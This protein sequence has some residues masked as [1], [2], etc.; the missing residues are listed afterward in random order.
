MDPEL[1]RIRACARHSIGRGF[2]FALLAIVTT[3]AGMIG[4]PV[5]AMRMGALLCML[6]VVVFVLR[7]RRAPLH[8]YR[9]TETWILL[10]RRHA[11]PE[12]RAQ[13]A[14]SGILAETYWRFADTSAALALAL[15]IATF[16]F[17]LLGLQRG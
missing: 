8:P 13:A 6:M 7:A 12:P 2:L 15:W 4:W 9:R 16:A 10:D 3:V 11:M 14:I 17:A 5:S 1:D